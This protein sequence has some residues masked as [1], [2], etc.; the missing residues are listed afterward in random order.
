M[1]P[2]SKLPLLVQTEILF[3]LQSDASVKKVIQASPS[4]LWHFVTYKKSAIRYILNGIVPFRTSGDILSDALI[5]IDISDQASA[6]R[7]KETKFWQSRKLPKDFTVEQLQILWRFFTRIVLFIEDYTSK[8]TSVYPPRAYLGIPDVVDGS[9]SYFKEQRLETEVVKFAA[10]TNAERHRFLSAFTRYELLCKIFH[11]GDTDYEEQLATRRRLAAMCRDSDCRILLS[12]HEYYTAL[13]GALFAHGANAWL[14]DI[15]ELSR[16]GPS[17][18]HF[19]PSDYGL[20]FP[21]NTYLDAREYEKDMDTNGLHLAQ[22]L[23]SC[24]LDCLMQILVCVRKESWHDSILRTWLRTLPYSQ[25]ISWT[26]LLPDSLNETEFHCYSQTRVDQQGRSAINWGRVTTF[27]P[28]NQRHEK[29]KAIQLATYR[30]R[31]WGLFDNDR[32]Y[33]KHTNHFPNFDDLD[34]MRRE[35]SEDRFRAPMLERKHRRSQKWQNFEE[36]LYTPRTPYS[37]KEAIA[38]RDTIVG[39]LGPSV[40]FFGAPNQKLPNNIR[41]D[42]RQV[43]Y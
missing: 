40:R 11:L 6:K 1:D 9:G 16:T 4:M 10:L 43:A 29:L 33:P 31:A 5:I 19:V 18:G 2:F 15:P 14:P 24:G 28:G 38:D 23:P 22:S 27:T 20:L 26:K 13:Y 32:L 34:R 37:H 35:F 41:E 39:H 42:W 17:A 7:Y 30:Q 36:V 21:D 12:V 25:S 8:A 3:H